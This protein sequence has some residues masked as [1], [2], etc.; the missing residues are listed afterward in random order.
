MVRADGDGTID[1]NTE[2]LDLELKGKPKK[3]RLFHLSTPVAVSGH[4]RGPKFGLKPGLAPLQAAGA[5]ALGVAL[6]PIAAILPFVDPGLTH[7]ADCVGLTAAF[8][9]ASKP[10]AYGL[11]GFKAMEYAFNEEG[12]MLRYTGE[13]IAVTPP[14]TI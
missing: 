13:T 5:V 6:S 7:D 10:D 2:A 11:R 1:L 14:L 3:V 12:I 9:M 4:L 8:D